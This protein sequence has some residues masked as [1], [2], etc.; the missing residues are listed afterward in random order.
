MKHSS[1]AER[2]QWAQRFYQSGLSQ[3]E[4]A[5]QHRLR[6]S[7]LQRWLRQNPLRSPAPSFAEIKLPRV[8]SRWA[9]EV[10]RSD[11]TVVRVAHDA[12]PALLQNLLAAC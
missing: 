4:F 1:P 9:L 5:A 8:T 7:T 2:V 12:S 3:R 11:G 10:I 6:L